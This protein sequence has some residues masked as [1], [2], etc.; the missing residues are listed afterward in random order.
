MKRFLFA[1]ALLLVSLTLSAQ[2]R[3][4]NPVVHA[5]YSDPDVCRVGEDYWMTASSFNC[6][7]GLPIL[8]S[9]D[10]VHWNLVGAALTEYPGEGWDAPEDDF[11]TTV[12]HGKAV[13]APAI[14]FH[15]GWYYI[16][17][18][19]PDRGVFMVR[20]QDPKGRWEPPVWVV[21]EK[22]FIDP[23]P[24]WDEDGNA[25]L[26]H[27][28]AGSRAGNKSILFVAPMAPDGTRLLGPSR[29]VYDGHLSQPTIEG[30]KFYK[31]DGKYYIFSPAG[32]VATG[33]Q[34]VLRA[35]NPF[36]PYEERIVMAWAPGTVNGPHQGAW[37]DTPA[38]E[39][40]FLH[41][42]DK[43]AYGRIVHLQPMAWQADGWPM[44]GVDPDG[45]GVGQ[46]VAEYRFL[47]SASGSARNDKRVPSVSNDKRNVSVQNDKRSI[48]IPSEVE[49]SE[50][51]YKPYGI[52]LAWQYPAIP[53]PYW[54][55][56][57]PEGGVR[58]YSVEQ[59]WPYRSLWD[60]PNFLAQKFP[61]ERFTV[62][63][64]LSFRPNP[65]LKEK[66]EQA[67][68]AVMG[69]DYAGLRLTDTE[70]G[71]KLEYVQCPGASKGQ[72]E[73]ATELA[74]L[75]YRYDPLPHSYESR[76]VPL[77]NY[78]DVPE[79]VLWV[80]LD[81]RAKV[82]E[83]NVPEAVCRFSYSLDGKRFTQVS[84]TFAAQPELW[85]GARFGFFCN[86]FAPKNDSGWV[87]VT[88]LEVK[89]MFEPAEGFVR[90][91]SGV[92][93]YTLP[94]VLAGAKTVKEWEKKRRP[95]LYALFEQEMFGTVPGKPET[96]HFQVRESAPDA[97]D[98]LAT[99]RQVRIYFDAEETQ[100]EDLL[101]YIPN[102]RKGPVP[103]FLGGNFRG[104][105]AIGTDPGVFLPD[106]LRYAR[107]FTLDP[108]GATSE[109]WP[110]DTIL[111]RGYAVVTFCLQDIVPDDV[112]YP[113]IRSLYEGYTW[114]A[115]AAWG[116]GLSRALDYLES[117][118]DVDAARVAVFGHSRLGK[119]ALW[120][121][122]RDQRFAMVVS[123]A[124]GCGGA[125]LS[126]RH[127]GE[128]VRRIN[129]HF[130]HW[131]CDNFK[132]YGDNEAMLPF[133]QH[134][135]L[136]LIAPRPLYVESASEDSWADPHGEFLSLAHAAPVY[137]L[138]GYEGFAPDEW[139]E[140]EHPVSKGR[141]GYHIR[142]GRHAILEYD[143]LRYLDFADRHL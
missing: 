28:C 131:F 34:T 3:Y 21:K 117:D 6:F 109:R 65:Q 47:D 127:F 7:P 88:D 42:Q 90:E 105:H 43:G 9:T 68:F 5:D 61:A 51:P 39:D 98:G 139:P 132:K 118:A 41:F 31:R 63:A 81:V 137:E 111:R 101:L 71:A 12:Q 36:G 52:D 58:L 107:D 82:V 64:R 73:T 125:A 60:C 26:S 17:V 46:P 33:W 66:G 112:G 8:H 126:R 95:E 108:R 78:P 2:F 25:Y 1:G 22:G 11:R 27:G 142:K 4:Q 50:S 29:I 130:P 84:G 91:E 59:K 106:T 15:E 40:W 24:F 54:H 99:R 23:C 113:G 116:W 87:D 124:S 86:R 120:A 89:T 13:W 104:N 133:D 97:L 140:V 94:D 16:Y 74:V 123:N 134:E 70:A 92:P 44:I 121:G 57:L 10:L 72:P 67:G 115:L 136:A 138:Y 18:G 35:D 14:R 38:G 77:V 128:T 80:M 53:S 110:L 143:W 83:G 135:L 85:V 100:Y 55:Y 20:T 129:M 122:A 76:N 103:A 119:A 19:D 49:E 45:D 32:G 56:A 30:T 62:R 75:P 69:N 79:I 48:V 93:A 96:L 141:N 37:V 102:G 114:G